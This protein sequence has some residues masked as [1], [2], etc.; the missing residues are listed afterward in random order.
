MIRHARVLWI[1]P[2]ALLLFSCAT[3]PVTGRREITLLSEADEIR[4]GAQ[5]DQAIVA[6]YGLLD[7]P[8]MEAYVEQIGERMV[9]VSH[10]PNLDFHFR[11]LDDP[12]VNAFAL[13]GGFVYITRGILA[14]L[15]D[16]AALAGVI[17]HEIGH[18]TAKHGVQQYT[19]QTLLGVGLAVGS[20]FNET[21]AGLAGT[22]G[23][24]L[25]LKYGRDDERESDRLGVE[26]ATKL[27]YDTDGMAEFFQTLGR[28]S[29]D[30]GGRLPSWASTHPDPGE[31]YGTVLQLTDQW[32]A[33]VPGTSFSR[34]R[35]AFLQRLEGLVFGADPRQGFVTGGEFVHPD[36]EFRFPVPSGWQYQN[37]PTQVTMVAPDGNL[38]V[39]FQGTG[40][41]SV[42]EA[43][44]QLA[45]TDG[46]QVLER[47]T[48]SLAGQTAL[49]TRAQAGT[50]PDAQEVSSTFLAWN[51]VVFVFH[52]IAPAGA[53]GPN[54]SAVDAPANGFAPLTDPAILG[55][56]PVRIRIV[57]AARSGTF[58]KA[59]ASHPV[60]D[61]A[62]LDLAGLALLNGMEPDSR[63]QAG[64]KLKVLR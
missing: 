33:Q 19:Q 24:L 40:A 15:N 42:A 4:L 58:R 7:D 34:D 11:V 61:A 37:A 25:L 63:V 1:V 51:G 35:A 49:R 12:I 3:N 46:I 48:V 36:L 39:I 54:R 38:G 56:E 55:V 59:V 31:R 41:S 62:G 29:G 2:L 57:E 6:Q 27:G 30:A 32:Q 22:A 16:E 14:Y 47:Q 8:S 20:V 21:V 18:V 53:L 17:G 13:P 26:Y 60:P 50:G 9:P 52:G 45:A 43:A 44:D 23:Q 64:E 10:R 28:L 5:S